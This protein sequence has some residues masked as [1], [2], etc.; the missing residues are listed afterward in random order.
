M[1]THRLIKSLL[2][3]A[4]LL[5]GGGAAEAQV[6]VAGTDFD[7]LAANKT[8]GAIS[9]ITYTGM[10]TPTI[11]MYANTPADV[12]YEYS[13]DKAN[14]GAAISSHFQSGAYYAVTANPIRLDSIGYM[15]FKENDNGIVF[16]PQGL[17]ANK[18]LM[19]F[20]VGGM[21][22]G[23]AVKVVIK[24]RS[25][26][27]E[28]KI[29]K[30]GNGSARCQFKVAVNEDSYNQT[31]G[32][33]VTQI[34]MGASSTFT[35]TSKKAD[36]SGYV[37]I[38]INGVS[39]YSGDCS[40]FEITSIE[41]YSD[42]NPQIYSVDGSPICAGEL[43]TLKSLSIYKGATYQW[44]KDGAAVSGAT[45]ATYAFESD[46][47]ASA[48]KYLLKVTYGGQTYTSNELDFATEVCCEIT[49]PNDPTKTVPAS[50]K[51][52]F[53]EDFGE[54]DLSDATGHTYKVW[55]YSDIANPKQITK[56]TTTP[57]RFPIDPAPL[58]VLLWEHRDLWL[59]AIIVWQVSLRDI[60]LIRAMPE[61]TLNGPIE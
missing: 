57:F 13:T 5:L 25:V 30:C 4:V 40:P 23:A 53:K 26:V 46:K 37:A 32:N 44:Y 58:G 10:I 21:V 27:D 50:R 49:D 55:D 3:T 14:K 56:T 38:N 31:Q 11:T 29:A 51:V 7:G 59:T 24:Y 45:N 6:L 39:S 18:T 43:A 34:A 28:T 19:T 61:L 52:V 8:W 47:T 20:K 15:D 35:M 9:D 48:H 41:V 33:D 1:K 22:P 16:S 2:L 42:I 36:A 17:T 54:F 12:D 60:M